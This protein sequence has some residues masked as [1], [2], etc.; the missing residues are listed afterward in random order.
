[1]RVYNQSGRRDNIYKAAHQDPR[2][3]AG[4]G[5]NAPPGRARIRGNQGAAARWRCRRRDRPH[6]APISR[7]RF[8]K[9]S[10]MHRQNSKRRATPTRIS[11]P[12]RRPIS[13][14]IA[15]RAMPSSRFRSSPSAACRAMPR[16]NSWMRIADL[17]DEFG[18]GEIRVSHE[19]NLVLPH[20]RKKDL[21]AIHARLEELGLATPNAGL[22]TDIIACPG[23]DYCDLANAR[24]IPI[25]QSIVRTLRRSRTPARYRRI[26]DQDFR[27]HQCLRPSSCRPYR[28][29]GRRQERRRI[30]PAAAGRLRR[31]RRVA[32]AKSWAPVSASMRSSMRSS[33]WST[34]ISKDAQGGERFLDT[35]RRIGIE[36]FKE[37]AYAGWAYH[38]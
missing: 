25:A 38:I 11:A 1:M 14:P 8:S 35:V 20:V 33:A 26:E 4:T 17:M 34:S 30:L 22:V 23:L 13:R 36:P 16:T 21:P 9:R 24:S 28:H 15:R 27:L 7:R 19:Q 32:S 10:A 5:G 29:S 3:R 12:G 18:I 2:Q 31:G 6:H 37:R